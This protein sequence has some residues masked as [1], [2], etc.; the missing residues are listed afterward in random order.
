MATATDDHVDVA[1]ASLLARNEGYAR[2]ANEMH[3][4]RPN[5][6]QIWFA[7]CL[8][9]ATVG[10][11]PDLWRAYFAWFPR[12]GAWKGGNSFRGFLENT[13]KEA[14]ANVTDEALRGE[15]NQLRRSASQRTRPEPT[16]NSEGP[17][18]LPATPEAAP[19]AGPGAA[20]LAPH[21][22]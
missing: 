18:V 11:T 13:R 6:Q 8:R 3:A 2:A 16:P 4:S 15:L 10:W 22:P 9:E 20:P 12:T 7:F 21:T 5:K 17:S 1:E 19:Q 14:L